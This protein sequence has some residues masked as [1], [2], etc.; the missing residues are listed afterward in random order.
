MA[1]RR[2]LASCTSQRR[3]SGAWGPLPRLRA[4][5]A[6]HEAP[7]GVAV[8]LRE[9]ARDVVHVPAAG[10]IVGL[11]GVAGGGWWRLRQSAG[12]AGVRDGPCPKWRRR[13]E[14]AVHE[15]RP[16]GRD[17][18][19]PHGAAYAVP[20]AQEPGGHAGPNRDTTRRGSLLHWMASRKRMSALGFWK[21]AAQRTGSTRNSRPFSGTPRTWR[22]GNVYTTRTSLLPHLRTSG[23]LP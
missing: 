9:R 1:R 16:G 4:L 15:H 19:L 12:V 2:V 17:R 23:T 22:G 21:A 6:L 5:R 18:Q 13:S 20:C 3:A 7:V 11:L 14:H 8:E 10:L